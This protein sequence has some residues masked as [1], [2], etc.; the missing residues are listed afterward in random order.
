MHFRK[1]TDKQTVHI[2]QQKA[3]NHA[4]YPIKCKKSHRYQFCQITF[5][6]QIQVLQLSNYK[7]KHS[8]AQTRNTYSFDILYP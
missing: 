1:I 6:V 5:L 8:S 3:N 2:L 4:F 7:E